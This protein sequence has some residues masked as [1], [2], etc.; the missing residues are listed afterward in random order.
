MVNGL[1]DDTDY[2]SAVKNMMITS[3]SQNK[4]PSDGERRAK[5]NPF[6]QKNKNHVTIPTNLIETPK[7]V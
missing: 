2:R 1:K 7:C 4:L 6:P 5:S 3:V